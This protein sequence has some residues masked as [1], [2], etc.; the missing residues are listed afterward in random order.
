MLG[1][2]YMLWLYQRVFFGELSNEKNKDLP[3]LNLREQWTLIPL[4]FIAFWVGLYR[5]T[6]LRPHGADR[7]SRPRAGCR[8]PCPIGQARRATTSQSWRICLPARLQG[9]TGS[10]R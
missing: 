8:S 2:A 10:S 3:D 6:V 5:Q 4:I 1:A 9:S 7:G